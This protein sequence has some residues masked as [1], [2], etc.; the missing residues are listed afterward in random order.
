MKIVPGAKVW[1]LHATHGFPLELSL[2]LMAAKYDA[3]PSWLPLLEA[4]QADGANMERLVRRIA[5]IAGEAY[6]PE[7][8]K[9]IRDRLPHLL[10][11]IERGI[12]T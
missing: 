3:L 7:T 11:A 12:Y 4:A 8:A 9:V 6:D 10:T 1:A 2:P 5:E